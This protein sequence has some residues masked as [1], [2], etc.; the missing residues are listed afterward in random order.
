MSH[1]ATKVSLPI[2]NILIGI[3]SKI[4]N[5]LDRKK[6]EIKLSKSY[7]TPKGHNKSKVTTIEMNG[8]Q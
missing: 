4:Y 5:K 8:F 3:F 1:Q 6:K 2:L 7:F